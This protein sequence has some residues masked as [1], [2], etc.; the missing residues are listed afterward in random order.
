MGQYLAWF[1]RDILHREVCNESSR[2][3]TPFGRG[4]R[5]EN[6][7]SQWSRVWGIC[8]PGFEAS[9]CFLPK[10]RAS[11][12]QAPGPIMANVAPSTTNVTEDTGSP[13]LEHRI[14]P[15]AIATSVPA[16]GV[17]SPIKRS[18]PATAPTACGTIS[19]QAVA[20]TRLMIP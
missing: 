10:R 1:H 17:H 4:A 14:H 5:S 18:I 11:I 8:G 16:T 15:L 6:S 13:A 2:R 7:R 12:D 3:T 19:A 20:S 9:M